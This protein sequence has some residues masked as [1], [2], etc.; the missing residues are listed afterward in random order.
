MSTSNHSI[1]EKNHFE[2]DNCIITRYIY[3]DSLVEAR[4][5]RRVACFYMSVNTLE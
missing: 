4:L 5:Y 1:F 3:V 2:I